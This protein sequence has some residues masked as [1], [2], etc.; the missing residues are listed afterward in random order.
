MQRS[1][2]P[3]IRFVAIYPGIHVTFLLRGS[4]LETKHNEK[5]G[6]FRDVWFPKIPKH[7]EAHLE[8]SLKRE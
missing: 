5:K 7:T 2:L 1:R 8:R 6:L 3:L 4:L